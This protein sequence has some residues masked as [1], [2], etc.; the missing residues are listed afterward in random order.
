MRCLKNT[1]PALIGQNE[2]S[3]IQH[4]IKIN[5]LCLGDLGDGEQLAM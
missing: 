2:I 5:S 4:S 1:Y 3:G